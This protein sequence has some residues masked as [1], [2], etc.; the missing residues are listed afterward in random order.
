MLKSTTISFL[1]KL[2]LSHKDYDLKNITRIGK[3]RATNG[4]WVRINTDYVK[5]SKTFYDNNYD[6]ALE[7]FK[8]AIEFRDSKPKY[9]KSNIESICVAKSLLL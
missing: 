6:G 2:G 5:C 3:K 4:W 1:R 9:I 7:A 8:A